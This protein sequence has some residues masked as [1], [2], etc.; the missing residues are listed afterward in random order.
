MAMLV[1]GGG[2]AVLSV[3]TVLVDVGGLEGFVVPGLRVFDWL[4][5][6]MNE[7]LRDG[8][9][10]PWPAVNGCMFGVCVLLL[11]VVVLA[12]AL[13][14]SGTVLLKVPGTGKSLMLGS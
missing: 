12:L 8:R 11:L 13:A 3:N 6:R 4:K 9:V 10:S 2:M 5:R 1:V 7:L 14:L